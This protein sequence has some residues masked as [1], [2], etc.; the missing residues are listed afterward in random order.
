MLP[1][2]EGDRGEAEF[3]KKEENKSSSVLLKIFV[4]VSLHIILHRQLFYCTSYPDL[5]VSAVVVVVNK[6]LLLLLLSC[7][8][9]CCKL[10]MNVITNA[11][12]DNVR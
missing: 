3:R 8:K 10:F 6:V 5:R 1:F 4:R 9:L 12:F 2:D 7:S 11:P